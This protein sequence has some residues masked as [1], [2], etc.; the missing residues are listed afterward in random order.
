LGVLEACPELEAMPRNYP[1]VPV[2]RG[3]QGRRI[4]GLTP[5]V[6][7]GRVS[8]EGL[9]FLFVLAQPIVAGPLSSVQAGRVVSEHVQNA[10]GR[11]GRTK[12]VGPLGH[13]GSHE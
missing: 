3:H 7:S 2:G 8:V 10:H 6:V 9:E 4:T 1:V 12:E 11:E 13:H 5:D